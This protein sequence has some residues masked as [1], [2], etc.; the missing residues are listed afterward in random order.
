M[1]NIDKNELYEVLTNYLMAYYNIEDW[2]FVINKRL[3]ATLG[4]VLWDKKELH[5]S[6]KHIDE[7]AFW[8]VWDTCQHEVAHIL[9]NHRLKSHGRAFQK[10]Y[11][12]VKEMF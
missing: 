10:N 4:Q 6:Q 7:D 9:T 5:I 1:K 2:K 12:M 8:Y 3:T 11:K